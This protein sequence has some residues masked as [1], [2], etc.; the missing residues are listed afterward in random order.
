MNQLPGVQEVKI[1]KATAMFWENVKVYG[2]EGN[3]LRALDCI[4]R[5][6]AIQMLAVVQPVSVFKRDG[7][8]II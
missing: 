1:A 3:A 5:D 6:E 8:I 7:K 4:S 2:N